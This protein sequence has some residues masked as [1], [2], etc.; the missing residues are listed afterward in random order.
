MHPLDGQ[1]GLGEGARPVDLRVVLNSE[2]VEGPTVVVPSSAA[3]A[4]SSRQSS[5]TA[6]GTPVVD[7]GS[8][9]AAPTWS[10][11]SRRTFAAWGWAASS[12]IG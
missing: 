1:A 7:S 5:R 9:S 3:A 8:N 2:A 11:N 6:N 4:N 10:A 12:C